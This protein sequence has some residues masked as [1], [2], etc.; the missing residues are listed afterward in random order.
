MDL[1]RSSTYKSSLESLYAT[2]EI[3]Q[4][5]VADLNVDAP[6]ANATPRGEG[7]PEYHVAES[8]SRRLGG[9]RPPVRYPK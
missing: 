4:Q 5:T 9:L 1:A 8:R 6:L 7:S 3:L 2:Q